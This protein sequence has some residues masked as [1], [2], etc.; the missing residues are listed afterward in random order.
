MSQ[1]SKTS[2]PRATKRL[3]HLDVER[4]ERNEGILRLKGGWKRGWHPAQ[5]CIPID[6]GCDL[7]L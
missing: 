2:V 3:E 5:G 4:E 1:N 7:G 6:G